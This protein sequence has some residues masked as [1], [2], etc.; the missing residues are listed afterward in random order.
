[1]AQSI[2]VLDFV[3]FSGGLVDETASLQKYAEWL[4]KYTSVH[5][6]FATT[7]HNVVDEVFN[8]HFPNRIPVEFFETL[9][10]TKL[11]VNAKNYIELS[12]KV[13]GFMR[14]NLEGDTPFLNVKKGKNGGIMRTCDM[15]K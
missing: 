3:V 10:L 15:Q 5:E 8:E 9:V 7:I 4:G 14:A 12:E 11:G 6:Q 1:M 13:N 2:S